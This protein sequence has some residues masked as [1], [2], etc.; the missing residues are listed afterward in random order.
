MDSVADRIK[1]SVA[2]RG[3]YGTVRMCW[4]TVLA[5]ALPAARR[6]EAERRQIDENF[7]RQYGVDT[8]GTFRPKAGEVVGR[9]WA[10]GNHYEAVEPCSF[11]ETLNKMSIPHSEFTFLD[12]GSGKGRCLLLAS[13]FG[14]KRIIGV[15][16]CPA[17]NRIARQN[18]RRYPASTVRSQQVE[19]VEGD[20]A[21][22]AIPDDPLVI[23][24][25]NAFAAPLMSKVARN[26]IDSFTRFPRRIVVVYFWP[27]F[28]NLW[29]QIGF[30][31]RVQAS[32]A[33]F[34]TGPIPSVVRAS[35]PSLNGS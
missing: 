16:F 28:A 34:D 30:L 22:F 12:F 4:G 1:R 31:K 3:L 8:G 5:R 18:V 24:V 19:I 33:V 9:N 11:I 10:L 20:A 26:V 7:D 21:E 14:F 32:P 25:N 15:E 29:E 27:F 17:L 6:R 35:G 23:F 2:Q 13:E